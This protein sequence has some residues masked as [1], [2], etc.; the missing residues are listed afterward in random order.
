[1]IG[2]L[3]EIVEIAACQRN[4][5]LALSDA[6]KPTLVPGEYESIKLVTPERPGPKTKELVERMNKIQ[7]GVVCI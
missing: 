1:M 6:K 2:I 3:V 4:F 5:T 7:V